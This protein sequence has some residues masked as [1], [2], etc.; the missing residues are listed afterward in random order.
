MFGGDDGRLWLL[1]VVERLPY[2]DF[3]V[4]GAR[5][6]E[7]SVQ[8]PRQAVDA[9]GVTAQGRFQAQALHR[10]GRHLVTLGKL[11]SGQE[12]SQKGREGFLSP[13]KLHLSTK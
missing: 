4:V 7:L 5:G 3:E 13:H 12:L 1:G 9:P 2:D 8:G 10:S 6:Q 11:P